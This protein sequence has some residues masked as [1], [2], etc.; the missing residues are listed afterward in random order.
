MKRLIPSILIALIFVN[1]FAPFTLDIN[2]GKPEIKK[3]VVEAFT[4]ERIITKS[5]KSF[6][7]YLDVYRRK[8][9]K[10]HWIGYAVSDEKGTIVEVQY[11]SGIFTAGHG[12]SL[13]VPTT[14]LLTGKN[15]YWLETGV[16]LDPTKT[17]LN[18][19]PNPPGEG[20]REIDGDYYVDK[21]YTITTGDILTPGKKYYLS[22]V[23]SNGDTEETVR[24]AKH[25]DIEIETLAEGAVAGDPIREESGSGGKGS[26]GL[27]AC[28]IGWSSGFS[29][30]GCIAQ[31]IYGLIFQPTAFLFGL[32]GMFFDFTF[33]YSISDGSYRTGFV[34]EGWSIV[35]DFVNLFFIFVLL[36][37]AFATILSLH[38]FKTKEMIINVVIIGLLINFSLF[39]TQIIIDTSNILA[40]VF[41]N[42]IKI[43]AVDPKSTI[44]EPS[45]NGETKLSEMIVNA[46]NPIKL[47]QNMKSA[48]EIEKPGDL[49]KSEK[50]EGGVSNGVFILITLLASAINI[51]GLIVFLTVGLMF[52]ARVIGLWFAMILVPFAFFSYT[53]PAMQDIDMLG[54]KKWWP[55]TLKL[56]FLAPIFIFFMYLIIKFL[57][58][59]EFLSV[60][61]DNPD[62]SGAE[63]IIGIIVPFIFIMVLM[64][65]AKSLAVKFSGEFGAAV[66]KA[67]AIVGGVALGVA[68]GGAA[69]AMRQTV[70][71][72]V[73]KVSNKNWLNDAA[74]GKSGKVAQFFGKKLKSGADFTAKS[75]FDA[76]QTVAG[77]AFSKQMGMDMNKGLGAVGLGTK[78]TLGGY[79]GGQERK[80]EKEN[81]FAESLGYDHK[82]YEEI[83]DTISAK[84][85]ALAKFKVDPKQD[86]NS[87]EYKG[88]IAKQEYDIAGDKKTQERVK[89][90]RSMEYALTQKRKSGKI[91]DI[92]V[93]EKHVKKAEDKY[94]KETD[95]K[96]KEEARVAYE[97]VFNAYVNPG[98]FRDENGN[99][100]KFGH[101]EK[102]AMHG[103]MEAMKEAGLGA[104]KGAATGMVVGS[105][106]PGIGT[107]L[108]M[109]IGGLAGMTR[110]FVN[111]SGTTNR[112]VGTKNDHKTETKDTYHPPA[113]S[114]T[115]PSPPSA[116]AGGAHHP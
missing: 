33:F 93:E 100:K 71:R 98:A 49:H 38:G 30:S 87:K 27:P 39:A 81:K 101:A 83:G 68:T 24:A 70:G 47:I 4:S 106:V 88:S 3:S 69:L 86:H 113:P 35:R 32:A 58:G 42:Q 41:Y 102:A 115:P 11:S 37:I 95:P 1:L 57:G 104:I 23:I 90:G 76:R 63:F 78:N 21:R 19:L 10:F 48:G 45:K 73:N 75:G 14:N 26:N 110:A 54:W 85:T 79:K 13:V 96:K 67:G 5:Q 56:A 114:A 6:T 64:M 116:P 92:D 16:L 77:N 17:P 99:I 112:M 55:E 105:V 91:F 2:K 18:P 61:K 51:V 59:K 20:R 66:S 25:I 9:T 111:H 80:I 34:L 31:L 12:A 103:F 36:Y 74:S 40:R 52:V 72:A 108:G 62:A 107:A 97:R 44:N 8:E 94:N 46:A 22:Y 109:G 89:T 60:I 65:K 53:V 7:V 43:E 29:V 84:E 82:K 15:N 28:W 50:N